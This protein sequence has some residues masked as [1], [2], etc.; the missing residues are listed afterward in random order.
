MPAV[1]YNYDYYGYARS[2]R[3]AVK[4]APRVSTS[5]STTKNTKKGVPASKIELK[6][7]TTRD[8]TKKSTRIAT[9][10]VVGKQKTHIANKPKE[11]TLKKPKLSAKQ[12][13]EE[14]KATLKNVT[15]A[16]TLFAL[17]FLISYRSSM[18]NESFNA[19]GKMKNKLENV[20]ILN[21][22]LESD[23]QTRTDLSYI[24]S[25]AKYQLG[26]QKPKDSQIQK[27]VIAKEDKI[28]TP[29]VIEEDE[30]NFMEKL[31]K[32]FLNVID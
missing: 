12:K 21:S 28:S 31:W 25:Y 20:E 10:E 15:Y 13:V 9:K 1:Q 14:A 22:Q 17:L 6:T 26:M 8:I 30:N 7:K 27:I 3:G 29:V 32:D 16:A 11:M 2:E 23:I 4:T 18:I 5:K 19:L 24:E